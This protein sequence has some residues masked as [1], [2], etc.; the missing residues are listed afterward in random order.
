MY[1][2]IQ[3]LPPKLAHDIAPLVLHTLG[4][5]R[6]AKEKDFNLFQLHWKG[7]HFR[8]RLGIAGGVDKN[9]SNILDWAKFGAGF[10]EVGTVTPQAQSA[11]PGRIID[12]DWKSK[13][14]WNKM[15]FPNLG[16]EKILTRVQKAKSDPLLSH[17]PLFI[18]LGKN[19]STSLENAHLDYQTVA[20]TFN[21]VA[22]AFVINISSPN[23]MGLRDLQHSVSLKKI[24]D[25]CQEKTK[26][27]LL[28][29]CSPDMEQGELLSVIDTCTENG[30]AGF[31]LTNTTLSRPPGNSF[32][33]EGG[34]SGKDL[35]DLSKKNLTTVVKHLGP[36][37]SKF[38]L[39]SV[40]G[41]LTTAD[42]AERFILGADLIQ[43][44][45][46]FVFHG[47]LFYSN[48]LKELKNHKL[49]KPEEEVKT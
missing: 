39:V 47:L 44:Y 10:I 9:A 31:I 4:S 1:S 34:L 21:D 40:G 20:S 22:D 24:I 45:S 3:F 17:T 6:S 11:N 28:V 43:C 30:V 32:S 2:L 8:N 35:A 26:K 7:M 18:N 48:V 36:D 27:P 42:V 46:A 14:L 15:G 38:L 16:Q 12:R 37:K 23:T 5:L 29:K 19:R 25:S 49:L 13:N 41:I 33:S